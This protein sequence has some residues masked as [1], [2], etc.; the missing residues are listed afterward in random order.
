M[1][2]IQT[3]Y[4]SPVP[5]ERVYGQTVGGPSVEEPKNGKNNGNGK[6]ETV[7]RSESAQE[8]KGKVVDT[9]A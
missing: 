8:A 7:E 4:N 6:N 5:P 9:Y 2:E 3:N 1:A